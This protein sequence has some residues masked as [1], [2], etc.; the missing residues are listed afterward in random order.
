MEK[1]KSDD[2][3]DAILSLPQPPGTKRLVVTQYLTQVILV[4]K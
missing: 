4:R 1:N 2:A 3:E